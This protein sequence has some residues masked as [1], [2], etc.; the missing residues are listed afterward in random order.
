MRANGLILARLPWVLETQ[1][2]WVI[3]HG[4]PGLCR[5]RAQQLTYNGTSNLFRIASQ[6]RCSVFIPGKLVW[7]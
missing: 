6:R 2:R 3:E 4:A 7:P 1:I 5:G